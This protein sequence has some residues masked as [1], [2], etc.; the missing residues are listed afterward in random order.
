MNRCPECGAKMKKNMLYCPACG[1]ASLPPV[2]QRSRSSRKREN[3]G[4]KKPKTVLIEVLIFVLL[5]ALVCFGIYIYVRDYV[6]FANLPL[7]AERSPAPVMDQPVP[8]VYDPASVWNQ[9]VL[10][11]EPDSDFAQDTEA[12]VEPGFSDDTAAIQSASRSVVELTGYN[13]EGEPFVSGSAFAAFEEG[14]FVTNWHVISEAATFFAKTETGMVFE[15]DTIV[16]TDEERDLAILR[17]SEDTGIE[18]LPL[19]DSTELEKGSKVI[20]IGSPLGLLNTVSSGVYSGVITLPED[21]QDYIQVSA[22]VS[23]GSSG[24]ALFNDA[25]EVV[26]I[27]TLIFAE[28]NNITCAIPIEDAEWLYDNAE[29][30]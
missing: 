13:Y 23:G 12:S 25:G 9:P 30:Y 17:T 6:P 16:A 5:T 19:G 4:K 11:E 14:V 24:G 7:P 1:T 10:S 18:P 21:G 22:P 8:S 3:S 15:L 26:G 28:G 2:K 29:S 27:T 20:A